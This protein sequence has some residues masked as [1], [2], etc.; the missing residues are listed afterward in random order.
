M[1]SFS[2]LKLTNAMPL[3]RPVSLS[4]TTL[5]FVGL[6]LPKTSFRDWSV[7]LHGRF[8]TKSVVSGL[9][10]EEPDEDSS[11]IAMAATER[12]A[13]ARDTDAMLR[14]E[15]AAKV[16]GAAPKRAKLTLAPT[17]LGAE[18]TRALLA[19]AKAMRRRRLL[20]AIWD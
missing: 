5:Q 9:A 18:R 3:L 16:R 2:L 13:L 6:K 11:D 14:A 19:P 20:V 17:A 12:K 4:V 15:A 1:A 8:P 10:A 7:T